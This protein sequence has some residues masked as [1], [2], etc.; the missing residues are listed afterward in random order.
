[1]NS[2]QHWPCLLLNS[3]PSACPRWMSCSLTRQISAVDMDWLTKQNQP[4]DTRL[5]SQGY[6]RSAWPT[7]CW[8]GLQ[9][10][11]QVRQCLGNQSWARHSPESPCYVLASNIHSASRWPQLKYWHR[12]RASGL[13]AA[14]APTPY[15]T[16]HIASCH[17]TYLSFHQ[18]PRCICHRQEQE[19]CQTLRCAFWASGWS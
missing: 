17:G 3:P 18:R 4:S 14:I 8:V 11:F 2:W 16:L 1:M 13:G 7:K 5:R 15:H 9:H 10:L 19:V 6:G 12:R